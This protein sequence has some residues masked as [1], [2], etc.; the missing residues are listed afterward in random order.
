MGFR[1]IDQSVGKDKQLTELMVEFMY[2]L[3]L[4]SMSGIAYGVI[5]RRG[6]S[7]AFESLAVGVTFSIMAIFAMLNP[8][9]L[10]E[11]IIL[12]P[13][14]VI[15]GLASAF[16]GFPAAIVSTL[17]VGLFRL[18]VGGVGAIAGATGIAASAA[19]GLVWRRYLYG[20]N[21]TTK[22]HLIGLGALL[23]LHTL[24]LFLLPMQ[25]AIELFATIVPVLTVSC[26]LGSLVMG[27]IID[28]ER[29]YIRTENYWRKTA[30][31]DSLTGLANRRSF[32]DSI[33]ERSP[34][35]NG[36]VMI[37]DID[38]FKKVN[39][40]FGHDAGDMVLKRVADVLR[41]TS[42]ADELVCRLGG[43]EFAVFSS[44]MYHVTPFSRAEAYRAGIERQLVRYG[45]E[46]IP[47]TASIGVS[48]WKNTVVADISS[49]LREADI[50]LYDA[51]AAGRNR[52]TVSSNNDEDGERP[53]VF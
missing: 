13:R 34:I 37:I 50:G 49:R 26:V 45:N 18:Y 2:G 9:V 46:T 31:T 15:V 6:K 16:G 22:L 35:R 19:L 40:T 38:H 43:E 41:K 51:K 12:D 4:M 29:H 53:L 33:Q 30:G 20:R 3:G 7:R 10:S 47:I 5:H 44:N 36:V 52:V 48:Y 21:S 14:A 25:V 27:S 32:L 28:R 39:D 24:T 11:G 23:S 8:L 17:F 1:W 42:T